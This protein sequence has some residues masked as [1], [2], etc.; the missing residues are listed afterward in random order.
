MTPIVEFFQ[1]VSAEQVRAIVTDFW[2]VPAGVV[3]LYFYGGIHFN[4]PDYRLGILQS[5]DT[6]ALLT[7]A[8][9]KYTTTRSR[10]RRYALRYILILEAAFLGFVFFTS[11]F[12]DIAQLLQFQLPQFDTQTLQYKVLFAL[13]FLTGLLSSFPGFKDVDAWILR[14]LHKA[15]LIPD[16]ARY[17]AS[18]LLNAP[19]RPSP[20]T[21]VQVRQ[22]LKS[23]DTIRC[24][25]GAVSGSLE[26]RVLSILWLSAQVQEK[27][28]QPECTYFTSKF[29]IDLNELAKNFT[30]LRSDVLAYFRDQERLVPP[31]AADI[32]QFLS[33]HPDDEEIG[34]LAQ[35]RKDLLG[36]CDELYYRMCLITSLLVYATES[37]P[38]DIGEF[39]SKL[40]FAVEIKANL[41][42]DWDTV[43]RVVG[44]VFVMMLFANA[45]FAG[46]VIVLNIQDKFPID[47]TRLLTF[48]F[49]Q[50][51]AYL[52]VIYAALKIK[53]HWRR[54][55]QV[56]SGRPENSLIAIFCYLLTLPI[57]FLI[58]YWL[59]GT[60]SHAPLL[61]AV[62]Q[63]IVGYFIA[64]YID[65]SLSGEPL[66][67]RLAGLQA[68]SLA[69]AALL[70]SF[71]SPG[72][73]GVE[74]SAM[75]Q[76]EL[77]AFFAVQQG[78]AGFLV[79][80][81]FQYFYRRTDR[82]EGQVV[83]DITVRL[84]PAE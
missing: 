7:L 31:D 23:R 32:D 36:Q 30:R 56:A 53:R 62:S 58:S 69:V 78:L 51:L 18:R 43:F 16:D 81:L 44:G 48:A 21:R 70:I 52:I 46:F 41:I 75:Q 24:S 17:M 13:F 49:T 71:F 14:K 6:P 2:T 76:T 22:N 29:Q 42:L 34:A 1:H 55:E 50:T 37:T 26:L 47:R 8:P 65:R 66:S 67:W 5:P 84:Q 15:A 45:L 72:L 27:A 64:T 40:G 19:Y 25:E 73:P 28:N 79:G 68:A 38:D 54:P 3:A 33:D 11:I 59:R 80:G 35:R 77:A 9:P 83:G 12:S 74:L 60:I 57:S 10:F 39:L 63:G 61:Y 20:N 4:T 82:P